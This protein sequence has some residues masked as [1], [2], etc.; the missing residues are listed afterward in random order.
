MR[1]VW[2]TRRNNRHLPLSIVMPSLLV[3]PDPTHS[4]A[5]YS[6]DAPS[7]LGLGDDDFALPIHSTL[8][9]FIYYIILGSLQRAIELKLANLVRWLT[10]PA[11]IRSKA[12]RRL[13]KPRGTRRSD[14][15]DFT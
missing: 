4:S 11:Y 12:R 15:Q 2:I 7:R 1:I 10:A 3:S 5:S 9:Y 13:V 14:L 6:C 8:C